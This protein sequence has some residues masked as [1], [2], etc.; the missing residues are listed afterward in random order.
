MDKSPK[1]PPQNFGSNGALVQMRAATLFQA[2]SGEQEKWDKQHQQEE[3]STQ[4]EMTIESLKH[5]KLMS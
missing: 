2:W 5:R 4:D 3:I 1:L